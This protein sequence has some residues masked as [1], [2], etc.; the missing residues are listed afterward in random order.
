MGAS[1]GLSEPR[2]DGADLYFLESRP[3]EAGRVVL[4]RRAADGTFSDVVPGDLNVRTRV[5]EYGGGAYAARDGVVVFSEF[6]GNRLMLKRDPG[7]TLEPLTG[8]AAL[9]FAD[10]E[11]DA[12][13]GRVI[14]VLE[15]HRDSDAEPRN[16]L[17]A[18]SL[19]DGSLD[20]LASGHDFYSHPRLSAEGT[21]LAWLT[22]DHP[23]MPW[24]GTDLWIARV[25]ADGSIGA[26]DHVAG[27]KTES[28]MQPVW[29]A[30]GTLVFVSDRSGWWN[31]YRWRIGAADHE[32]LL[33]TEAEVGSP[34]WVFGLSDLG[35]DGDGTVVVAATGKA[36]A[37]LLAL[38]PGEPPRE[39]GT[40]GR[41]IDYLRVHEGIASFG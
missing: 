20:E 31:P 21:R 10:M 5:H 13:R 24:N 7:A 12:A 32:T 3:D 8:D 39:F 26:P 25:A 22:W 6:E 2:P 11:I 14:A 35:I 41:G 15:D 9:R 16:L 27:G 19:A 37:R 34:Q 40:G 17:C 38:A 30:D 4:M 36:G 28:V 18:V 33:S 1:R 23:D 29:A